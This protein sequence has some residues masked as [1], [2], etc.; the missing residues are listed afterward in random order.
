M[1]S[2]IKTLVVLSTKIYYLLGSIYKNL[3]YFETLHSDDLEH[4]IV[5]RGLKESSHPF[6]KIKE[7]YF[8]T[9]GKD[10]RLILT[11]NL[12]ILHPR[13][14]AH[15]IDSDGKETKIHIGNWN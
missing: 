15:T 1:V 3:R 9:L 4:K 6:N 8:K 7:V 5:K 13:F 14:D 11:P 2:K 12:E 10:F